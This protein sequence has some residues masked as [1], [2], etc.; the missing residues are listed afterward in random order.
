MRALQGMGEPPA[1][2]QRGAGEFAV[3]AAVTAILFVV[4]IVLRGIESK[5]R[6]APEQR[7]ERPVLASPL[8]FLGP[9][10]SKRSAEI[11]ALLPETLREP[12]SRCSAGLHALMGCPNALE[13]LKTPRGQE[14]ERTVAEL[15]RG[16]S[17]QGLA[18][19]VLLVDLARHT[20]WAPGMFVGAEHSERIGDL[21]QTW[22]AHFGEPS[23]DDVT[24]HEPALAAA[25]LYGRVMRAAYE[26][27]TFGRSEAPYARARLFTRELC[28][29]MAKD[30]TAF[31]RALKQ[32]Y[33]SAFMGLLEDDFLAKASDEARLAFPDVDG[34][35]GQ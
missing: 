25:L 8:Q 21:L 27:P 15:E 3:V 1:R 34:A 29:T 6:V 12:W 13:W 14:F 23:A 31:G 4:A 16:D 22:L 17:L 33:P 30:Q 32:R 11:V 10:A 20:K 35:C 24:L 19:L 5:P 9:S 18:A 28:G 26:S 2:G 7:T